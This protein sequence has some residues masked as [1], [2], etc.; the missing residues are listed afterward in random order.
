MVYSTD[1]IKEAED[2]SLSH[3][4]SRMGY[5]VQRIGHCFTIKEMDSFRIYH[6]R[7]W[8]RHSHKSNTGRIGGGVLDFLMEYGNMTFPEAV[9]WALTEKGCVPKEQK[10]TEYEKEKEGKTFRLPERHENQKRTFAYLIKKRGLSPETI[11]EFIRQGILYESKAYHNMVFLGK[12]QDGVVRF[13]SMRGTCDMG[14]EKPFKCDVEGNDKRY[15]VNLYRE[16]SHRVAVFEGCVDM[17]SYMELCPEYR[18]SLLTLG[19]VD[20]APLETFLLEHKALTHILLILDHDGAGREATEQIRKKYEERGYVVE[21][22]PYPEAF[23]D[24]NAY[25][26]E[27]KRQKEKQ[28]AR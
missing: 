24:L 19:M 6:D 5:Q 10:Y 9:A 7:T 15:G 13:A 25:L 18:E 8:C 12:D 26:V 3:V 22:Y 4:A 11:R 17:M 14:E 27:L 20:D 21:V 28:K 16:G 2:I 1:E 23:K